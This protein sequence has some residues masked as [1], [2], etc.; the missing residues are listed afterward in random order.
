MPDRF[1]IPRLIISGEGALG[2]SGAEFRGMGAKAL[3][4]SDATMRKLGNTDRLAAVMDGQGVKYSLFCEVNSEPTDAIVLQGARQYIGECCDFLVAIGGGSPIDAMKA[5][6]IVAAHGGVPRDYMGKTVGGGLPPMAAIPTTAGTGSE[7]TQ[8]TIIA[9]TGSGVKMLLKGPGLMPSLAV[10]DPAFTATAPPAVTANT[11]L[12][13]LCH[14]MEAFLSKKAQPLSD[15]F[16]VSAARRILSNLRGACEEPGNMERRGQMAL[17]ATE[18]GIAFS[19]SSV[20]LVHGMS[21]PIGAL[22]HVP[23]GLSNAVLM[24]AC[25]R[26]VRE[27]AE[28]RFADLARACG[29]GG[30]GSGG[31][32]GGGS[33]GGS[34]GNSGGGNSD[35][36]DRLLSAV[37]GLLRALKVPSLKEYGI[38]RAAFLEQ[39][40]KM[41]EDALMSGSPANT[42][43]A[44]SS[45]DI[46]R[47]Y[48]DLWQNLN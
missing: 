18:A 25:F 17:A 41:T 20:T 34:D 33:G 44:V 21:R 3:I 5:I 40:P 46:A 22:F 2:E 47:L 23:H 32:P 42:P 19:N 37:S 10:A 26:L 36:A 29:M 11:G 39:I 1:C 24:E 6:G 15:T 4:V 30:G 13:A 12:D 48:E 38:D 31:G 45:G 7:A 28:A 9:D 43:C 14:A 8:F 27:R 16:A 35:A